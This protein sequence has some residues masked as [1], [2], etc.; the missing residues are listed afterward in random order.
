[1]SQQKQPY[2]SPADEAK[3]TDQR[4]T[5]RVPFESINQ[6]P[7]VIIRNTK[8]ASFTTNML[9][10]TKKKETTLKEWMDGNYPN[11]K[12]ISI[13]FVITETVA[14]CNPNSPLNPTTLRDLQTFVDALGSILKVDKPKEEHIV[15][16]VKMSM[17]KK[18]WG[19]EEKDRVRLERVQGKIVQMIELTGQGKGGAKPTVEKAKVE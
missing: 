14:G 12:K 5:F 11:T 8:G 15:V 16:S 1:M 4:M 18:G 19:F 2:I 10:S 6:S 9:L 3:T 13:N 7:D 17:P